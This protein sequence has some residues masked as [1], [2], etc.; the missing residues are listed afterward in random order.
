MTTFFRNMT[1]RLLALLAV[2]VLAFAQSG[3]QAQPAYSF[4]QQELDQMLAPIALYPDA[5]LSQILMAATYPMEV[6]EA[7]RWAGEH[8]DFSGDE[9]V[10]A[11]E[12]E[13]WDPSVKSLVAFPQV[14]ARMGE[15]LQWTQSLGDAFLDQQEQVMDTVQALRRKAQA[16]GNLRS[17]DRLSVVESGPRLLVQPLDP[18]V[19]YVPYYDP[20]VVYGSWWWPAYPPVY[21]RPWPGYYARPAYARGF[22]WG[23][24]V[25]ISVGF[26]FGT[27]D[28]RQRQVRVVHVNNYYYN[29]TT[30]RH[31]HASPRPSVQRPGVWHHD[32]DRRRG[33]DHGR[34]DTRQRA[35]AA[36]SPP[37]RGNQAR[38]ANARRTDRSM[39]AGPAA[40]PESRSEGRRPDI[41][42][43][44]ET[45]A[46]MQPAPA[47]PAAQAA[48]VTQSQPAVQSVPALQPAP[49]DRRFDR[50]REMRGIA[51][52]AQPA[53]VMGPV[54]VMQAAP[55]AQTAP[56]ARGDR[57][58]ARVDPGARFDAPRAP[59]PRMDVRHVQSAARQEPAPTATA[60]HEPAA[61]HQ[62]PQAS[63]PRTDIRP[64]PA[65][66]RRESGA[67][68][69]ARRKMDP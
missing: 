29:P 14:L 30:V 69:N 28:W 25:G 18:Q 20:L 58:A 45:R 26:F 9:A 64:P 21:W 53:A 66:A 44:V 4:S 32:P 15:N 7:A 8:P 43:A 35:G 34:F 68:A 46:K 16:A 50:R 56:A 23:S 22:Y 54:P 2:F 36:G 33:I 59:Q 13:D 48:P 10:R 19:V 60:R 63:A 51:Q 39:D 12:T 62:A 5:L 40:R 24:P 47:A 52:P 3:A 37:D 55:A 42:P 27:I 17:D 11:A 49:A 1:S 65:E 57:H 6:I 31:A 41:P 67:K 61:R 38:P